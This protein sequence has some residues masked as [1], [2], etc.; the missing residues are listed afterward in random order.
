MWGFNL[1]LLRLHREISLS[2]L[3]LHSSWCSGLVLA[4]PLHVGCLNGSVPCLNR[5]G[6]KQQLIRALLLTQA[7]EREEYGSHIWNVG[8]AWGGRGQR[9]IATA[10]GTLCVLLGK[11]SLDHGPLAVA[12]CTGSLGGVGSE[13]GLH[14]GFLVVAAAAVV[15][16]AHLWGPT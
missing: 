2:I 9:E 12:G 16:C 1:L 15:V 14:I 7:G 6:L 5:R 10:R 3:C 11:L 4:P 8:R 13:L